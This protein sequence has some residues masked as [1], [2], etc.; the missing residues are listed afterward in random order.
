MMFCM[1]RIVAVFFQCISDEVNS[2]RLMKIF[3]VERYAFFFNKV[4]MT[5]GTF[6]TFQIGRGIFSP[7]VFWKNVLNWF[8]FTLIQLN[9]MIIT[10]LVL[11]IWEMILGVIRRIISNYMVRSITYRSGFIWTSFFWS[12]EL[13]EDLVIYEWI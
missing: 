11:T 1:Q 3:L 4:A 10:R 5:L 7:L 12:V 8:I 2:A 6:F 13:D 9:Q